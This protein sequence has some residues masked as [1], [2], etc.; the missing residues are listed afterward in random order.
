LALKLFYGVFDA[1]FQRWTQKRMRHYTL[2]GW[3]TPQKLYLAI[4]DKVRMRCARNDNPST[5]FKL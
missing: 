2:S 4:F 1:L 5:V 3:P